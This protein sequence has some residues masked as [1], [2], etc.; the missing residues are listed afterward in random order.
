MSELQ[1]ILLSHQAPMNVRTL[2]GRPR[3]TVRGLSAFSKED[4]L[5]Q[6]DH[7]PS[8]LKDQDQF[9]SIL[10]VLLIFSGGITSNR[11]SESEPGALEALCTG[12]PS[13]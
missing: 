11:F 8:H 2:T 12:L 4:G 1:E 6:L 10:L 7:E 9:S 13:W 5:K 3:T